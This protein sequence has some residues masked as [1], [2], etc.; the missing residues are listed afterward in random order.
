MENTLYSIRSRSHI[1]FPGLNSPEPPESTFTTSPTKVPLPEPYPGDD[2]NLCPRCRNVELDGQTRD[3]FETWHIYLGELLVII[4][5]QDCALCRAITRALSPVLRP[6]VLAF[7][8]NEDNLIHLTA[9]PGSREAALRFVFWNT[10]RS[11]RLKDLE[12]I[13]WVNRE[14][15]AEGNFLRIEDTSLEKSKLFN[16]TFYKLS[17]PAKE[18]TQ[19]PCDVEKMRHYLRRCLD[20]HGRDCNQNRHEPLQSPS[21]PT[22]P[23]P[24]KWPESFRGIDV[25]QLQVVPAPPGCAYLA[26]S[27]VWDHT[28]INPFSQSRATTFPDF[29]KPQGLS[30]SRL[31]QTIADALVV[32]RRLGERYLWIDALCIIQ[33]DPAD[34]AAQVTRMGE[35]YSLATATIV[36]ACGSNASKGLTCLR[37]RDPPQAACSVRGIQYVANEPPLDL[38]IKD[39]LWYTRG[40]TY[41]EYL[42]SKRLIVF[43]SSQVFFI[44]GEDSCPEDTVFHAPQA[45]WEYERSLHHHLVSWD[46]PGGSFAGSTWKLYTDTVAGYTKRQL[47]FASDRLPAI[48]GILHTFGLC[49]EDRFLCGL[50]AKQFPCALLWQPSGESARSETCPSWSWA[51]WT[52]HVFHPADQAASEFNDSRSPFVSALQNLRFQGANGVETPIDQKP[53][54]NEVPSWFDIYR[55]PKESKGGKNKVDPHEIAEG[56]EPATDVAATDL[57]SG[58]LI[59]TGNTT[60][61]SIVPDPDAPA[62]T[63]GPGL[64][65]YRIQRGA[66]WVGTIYLT[67]TQAASYPAR[68]DDLEFLLLTH[69]TVENYNLVYFLLDGL[70]D[71]DWADENPAIFY[72]KFYEEARTQTQPGSSDDAGAPNRGKSVRPKIGISHVM[73]FD[74]VGEVIERKAV[75]WVAQSGVDWDESQEF[76]LG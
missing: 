4:N 70:G 37:I 25:E 21:S 72:A 48:S 43:T 46:A 47:T 14:N 36:A 58:H 45:G 57:Q 17:R 9:A 74:R 29:C 33:D 64:H 41:Q 61:L 54:S 27:Y 40:W 3:Y 11:G 23:T 6:D 63:T 62:P 69:C 66:S 7:A 38:A 49:T 60:R 53:R 2:Q 73:L 1:W 50:P 13:S 35:I 5:T 55:P 34:V 68:T 71:W 8:R 31:P 19:G 44:C 76:C 39:T 26:L 24:H 20:Q 42:L 30:L 16:P 65:R 22:S 52:G 15:R 56:A 28:N 10:T 18:L 67:A 51:G 59:F 12:P 32:C 75:G